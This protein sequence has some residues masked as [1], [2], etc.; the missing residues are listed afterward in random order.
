MGGTLSLTH[1]SLSHKAQKLIWLMVLERVMKMK[2]KQR[3]GM[4][5]ICGKEGEIPLIELWTQKKLLPK[6]Y[7]IIILI[8]Q[9]NGQEN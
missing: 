6:N 9:K 1:C 7:A 5:L 4:R 3:Y 8:F 2:K